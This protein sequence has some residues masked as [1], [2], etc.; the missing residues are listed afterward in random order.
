M[1]MRTL[2]PKQMERERSGVTILPI[3]EDR[4]RTRG[5]CVNGARPCPWAS[6]KHHLAL[7]VKAT[8]AIRLAMGHEDVAE[9]VETCSLDVADGGPSTLGQVAALLGVVREA[10][11]VIEVAA[12]AKIQRAEKCAGDGVVVRLKRRG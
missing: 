3:L 10:V 4:P 9:M 11:R 2:R 7:D 1:V 6:C 8:G 5:D 12:L